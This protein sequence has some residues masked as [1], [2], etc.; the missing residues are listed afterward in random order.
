MKKLLILTLAVIFVMALG[1]GV[2]ANGNNDFGQDEG[3]VT[4]TAEV[5][6]ALTVPDFSIEFGFIQAINEDKMA[7]DTQDLSGQEGERVEISFG[8]D[9]KLTYGENE[10]SY[11]LSVSSP[12][13]DTD[14]YFEFTDDTMPLTVQAVLAGEGLE[15]AGP[16][17]YS[18]TSQFTVSYVD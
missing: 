2:M 17:D 1:A 15:A 5:R 7:D 3:D 9:L 12:N 4:V 18:D 13:A 14:G 16:G 11:F 10:I 8:D 6:R